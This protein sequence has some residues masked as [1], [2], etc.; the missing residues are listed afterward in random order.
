LISI[1]KGKRKGRDDKTIWLFIRFFFL[2]CI[3]AGILQDYI[4]ILKIEQ[5]EFLRYEKDIDNYMFPNLL[6]VCFSTESA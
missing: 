6:A 4:I 1:G 5:K 3:F 2:F